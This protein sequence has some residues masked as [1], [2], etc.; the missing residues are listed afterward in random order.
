MAYVRLKYLALCLQWTYLVVFIEDI[1]GGD[2][3]WY[4]V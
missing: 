3:S 4:L 1:V 2:G